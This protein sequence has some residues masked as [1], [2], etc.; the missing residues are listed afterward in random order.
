MNW[1]TA[2]PSA[3]VVGAVAFRAGLVD[4]LHDWVAVE[5]QAGVWSDLHSALHE[6]VVRARPVRVLIVCILEES[7]SITVPR[8][9]WRFRVIG[10]RIPVGR[11]AV[12]SFGKGEYIPVILFLSNR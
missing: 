7:V 1:G 9:R 10:R 8:G 4:T 3:A 12:V 6:L 5:R 11:R 2:R